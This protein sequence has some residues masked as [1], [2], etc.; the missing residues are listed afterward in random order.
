LTEQHP[1]LAHLQ[2]RAIG[3]G[4]DNAIYQLGENLVVRLPRRAAAAQLIVN[5]QRWLP[6]LSRQVSLPIPAPIRAGKPGLG[7]PW[8]WSVVPWLNGLTADIS[9]PASTQAHVLGSFLRS[10]HL[11]TPPDA[12]RNPFRGVPLRERAVTMESRMH[13]LAARTELITPSAKQVWDYALEAPLDRSPTWLHGDL[14]PGNVLVDGGVI[15]GI[16]DWGD[17]TSGDPATDLASCWTLFPDP[18]CRKE[19]LSAYGEVSD[20]TLCRAKGWALLFGLVL[21]ETGL[22]DNPR[23]A[24]IGEKILRR[25]VDEV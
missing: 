25:V 9:E 21:L 6:L 14:H 11:P 12:P 23:H 22:G 15:T 17:V 10:L 19:L 8:N 13:R 1:D 20:P 4:W 3:E 24:A 16:I 2:L 5:E 18:C 7:Y